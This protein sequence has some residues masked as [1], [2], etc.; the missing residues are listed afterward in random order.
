MPNNILVTGSRGFIG[1]NLIAELNNRSI[2]NVFGYDVDNAEDQLEDIVKQCDFIFHLAGVNRPQND[3][4]FMQGNFGFTSKLLKLLENEKRQIPIL[5][6]SSIQAAYENPYGLSKKAGEDIIKDYGLKTGSKT[7]IYRLPNVFGKWSQP[8]Y[9]TVVATFCHKIARD[10]EIQINDPN[11]QLTLVYI[12]DVVKEFISALEDKAHKID[13]YYKIP[14]EHRITL[15]DLAELIRSFK[16]SRND[17]S[18][19]DTSNAIENKLYAT[20]LSFLHEDNF[21]YDLKMNIDDRGSFTEFLRTSDRGQVSIN[22]SKPGI[23]K[24]NHWHHTKN[25]KYLVVS[26]KASIKF[27]KLN[28]DKVIEYIVTG[29][30]LQVVDIPIGYTHSI[31]N[32]GNN[33]LVT[34][35][36]VNECFDSEK[37]DTYFL[38]V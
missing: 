16:S 20:Y 27:R 11:V 35:M 9:N 24:G 7:Y 32:I 2:G 17:L 30:K 23:T 18:L 4:E 26:G 10:E 8:N 25:E 21:I 5:I 33:D 1:K 14:L 13:D 34:V 15:G 22:V 29:E 6:T 36:W 38:K 3:E 37:P 31:Q 12:D 19:I 28:Q